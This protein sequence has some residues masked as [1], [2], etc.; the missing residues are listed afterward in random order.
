MY[1]YKDGKTVKIDEEVTSIVNAVKRY[2]EI[3]LD[4]YSQ[5]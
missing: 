3:D 1:L 5:Q 2:D 4:Y